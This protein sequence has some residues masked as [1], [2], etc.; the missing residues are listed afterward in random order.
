MTRGADRAGRGRQP[1]RRR[2]RDPY[3]ESPVDELSEPVLPR[4]FVLLAVVTVPAAIA[5]FAL[6]F[7]VL[8][9][10]DAVPPAQRRPPPAD[11]PMW[12]ATRPG[13]CA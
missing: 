10:D 12:S 7:P 2:V 8:G 3:A 5:V 6:A 9:G 1:R 13:A 4:W 11:P